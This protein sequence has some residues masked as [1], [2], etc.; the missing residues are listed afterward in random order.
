MEFN[1]LLHLLKFQMHFATND[2]VEI[3]QHYLCN[4]AYCTLYSYS[5]LDENVSLDWEVI[6]H[7]TLLAMPMTSTEG[8]EYGGKGLSEELSVSRH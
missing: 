4:S 5:I 2:V 1:F 7:R 8:R 3:V 6:G